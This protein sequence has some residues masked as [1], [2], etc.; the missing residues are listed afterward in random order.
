MKNEKQT[1]KRRWYKV[2]AKKIKRLYVEM[3]RLYPIICNIYIAALCIEWW[4]G[5]DL[6]SKYIYPLI[7]DSYY[8]IFL[9]LLGSVVHRFCGIYR[10]YLANMALWLTFEVFYIHGVII[11]KFLITMSITTVFLFFATLII[12]VIE[13]KTKNKKAAI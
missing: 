2:T 7:G 8:I 13:W 6:I 10:F 5:F 9:F 4:F 11:P 12:Y 1:D 3:F